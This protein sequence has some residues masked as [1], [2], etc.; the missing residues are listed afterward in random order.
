MKRL[1]QQTFDKLS[2]PED[3]ARALRAKLVSQ[4]SQRKT[5]VISMKKQR[6]LWIAA[7]VI[8]ALSLSAFAGG[9][10]VVY[11]LLS[12]GDAPAENGVNLI[13]L[14]ADIAQNDY[15]YTEENGDIV[16]TLD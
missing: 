13:D 12:G 15:H 5:E 3:K 16:V 1:Y 4:S 7:A 8:A 11:R 2:M 6:I 9:Y 10:D 14:P